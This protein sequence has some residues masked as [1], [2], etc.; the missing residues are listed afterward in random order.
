MVRVICNPNLDDISSV[1]DTIT[2]GFDMRTDALTT[3]VGG[4]A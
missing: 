3:E 1:G 2:L 4:W